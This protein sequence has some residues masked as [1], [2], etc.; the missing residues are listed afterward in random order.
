MATHNVNTFT[1]RVV[2]DAFLS[3]AEP[4]LRKLFPELTPSVTRSVISTVTCVKSSEFVALSTHRNYLAN[5][6]RIL[7]VGSISELRNVVLIRLFMYLLSTHQH[8]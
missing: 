6:K 8:L 2:T 1:H 4:H 5:A 3:T 7:G